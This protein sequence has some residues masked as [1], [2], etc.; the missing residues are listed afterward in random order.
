MEEERKLSVIIH[1]WIEHNESHIVEYRRWAQ[2]A[3]ELGLAGVSKEIETAIDKL[4]QC[5]DN[6]KKAMK[7]I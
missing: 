3:G 6:L 5:N 2:K 7:G 4:L 1:H